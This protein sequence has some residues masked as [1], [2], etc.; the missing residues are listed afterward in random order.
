MHEILVIILVAIL[1]AKIGGFI[2]KRLGQPALIG[3]IVAGFLV[4]PAVLGFIEIGPVLDTFAWIGITMLMFLVGLEFNVISFKKSLSRGIIISI[5]G[6]FIPFALGIIAGVTVLEMFLPEAFFLGII[7]MSTSV[8]ITAAMLSDIKKLKSFR[9][10]AIIDACIIGDVLTVV[11]LTFIISVGTFTYAFPYS[12]ILLGLEIFAFFG[13]VLFFGPHIGK[14]FI[15][16]GE[17]LNLRV[18]EGLLSIVLVFLFSMAFLAELLGLSLITGAFLAGVMINKKA[19][20]KIQHELYGLT[21]GLFVPIFF[22]FIGLH[23]TPVDLSGTFN[24][25]LFLLAVAV[26]SK[27]LGAGAGAKLTGFSFKSSLF[28]GSAMVPR[29]ELSFIVAIIAKTQG[30]ITSTFY[31]LLVAVFALTVLVTPPLLKLFKE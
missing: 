5:F 16:L 29:I 1:A 12:I 27:I 4:G 21:Y 7:L 31:T 23:L 26:F 15:R 9:G 24:I 30:Y 11:M 17:G 10:F 28:I 13:I 2:S 14:F 22:V 6:S 19:I 3:E 25:M 18:R 20:K 8:T